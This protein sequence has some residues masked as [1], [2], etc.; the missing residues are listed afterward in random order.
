MARI[1]STDDI[2]ALMQELANRK[3]ADIDTARRGK[4]THGETEAAADT[5]VR[6]DAW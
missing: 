6:L 2:K 4:R 3:F 5:G 1:D